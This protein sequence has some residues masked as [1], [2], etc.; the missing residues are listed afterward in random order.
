MTT[1]SRDDI[2]ACWMTDNM[3]KMPSSAE[4]P[5]A[6]RPLTNTASVSGKILLIKLLFG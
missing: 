4:L 3:Q 2:I 5:T 1:F 6:K